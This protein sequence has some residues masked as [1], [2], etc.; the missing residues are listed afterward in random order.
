MLFLQNEQEAVL[1][2]LQ[3]EHMDILTKQ[4]ENPIKCSHFVPTQKTS[5]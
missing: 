1:K 5:T 3:D 2:C 4:N